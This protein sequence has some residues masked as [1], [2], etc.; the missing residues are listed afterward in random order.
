MIGLEHM[1]G[2]GCAGHAFPD[3]NLCAATPSASRSGIPSHSPDLS[4]PYLES[5]P[6]VQILQPPSPLLIGTIIFYVLVWQ[7]PVAILLLWKFWIQKFRPRTY[8]GEKTGQ[9]ID[10]EKSDDSIVF[11]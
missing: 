4:T 8:S 3:A 2:C 10:Y 6:N 1:S 5:M 9:S 11:P 7:I